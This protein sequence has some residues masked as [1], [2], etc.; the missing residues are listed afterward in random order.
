[1]LMQIFAA[2]LRG[3]KARSREARG[4]PRRSGASL[5]ELDDETLALAAQKGDHLAFGELYRRYAPIYTAYARQKL[6]DDAVDIVQTVFTLIHARLESYR[7]PL[8]FPWAYRICVNAVTDELRRRRRRREVI[9][10][11]VEA[12]RPPETSPPS[13]EEEVIARE[14]LLRLNQD[15]S[16]LPDQQ[17]TVFVLARLEG[18]SYKEIADLMGIPEGTVKSRMWNAIRALFPEGASE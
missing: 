6:G 15:L 13:P 5:R 8:W 9:D 7:G 16:G 12:R 11:E 4:E 2:V 3:K 10:G 14:R 1:M 18:L 17:R